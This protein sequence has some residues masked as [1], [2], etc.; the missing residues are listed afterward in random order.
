MTTPSIA[1]AIEMYSYAFS[2]SP[3]KIKL[4]TV[5]AIGCVKFKMI[6]KLNGSKYNA[7][8]SM[9]TLKNPN[10]HLKIKNRAIGQGT[11]K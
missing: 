1:T 11:A 2:F 4:I 10:T 3:R 9:I 6:A 7:T 5:T 8:N